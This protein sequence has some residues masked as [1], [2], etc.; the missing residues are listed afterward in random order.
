MGF[1]GLS[2]ARK[3]IELGHQVK[4]LGRSASSDFIDK[5]LIHYQIDLTDKNFDRHI[6][7]DIDVVF[8]VAA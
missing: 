5:R 8:H 3:L 2:I 4:T 6:L 1:I 7:N